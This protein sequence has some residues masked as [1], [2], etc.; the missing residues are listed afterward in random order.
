VTVCMPG[1]VQFFRNDLPMGF[2]DLW[3]GRDV[4]GELFKKEAP[5]GTDPYTLQRLPEGLP[6]PVK[7]CW[8]GLVALNAAPF[9]RHNL[10][11]RSPPPPTPHLDSHM[12][13]PAPFLIAPPFTGRMQTL[14][15]QLRW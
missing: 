1:A 15:D 6:F 11:M 12:R 9:T 10:K 7:C 5:Y 3:V 14:V 13:P 4:N 2:Y 8:N